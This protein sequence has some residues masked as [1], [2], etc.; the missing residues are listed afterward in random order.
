VT[1]EFAEPL[2]QTRS[3]GIRWL[4]VDPLVVVLVLLAAVAALMGGWILAVEDP[5]GGEPTAI[6]RIEPAAAVAEPAAQTAEAP[7]PPLPDLETIARNVR[8]LDPSGAPV[9][10]A[11]AAPAP[12]P[13]R[14]SV[15]S[16]APAP[17]PRLVEASEHGSLPKVGE[18]GS[19]AADVYARPVVRVA[20]GAKA[21]VAIVV[22]G[23]GL[24]ARAT[25]DAI[26]R[27]PG[28]VT[29]AFV[30]YGERVPEAA[31]KA[32]QLGHELVLQ[33][34]MEPFDYPDS[35]PGPKAL[36]ASLG[37]G[38][39]ASRLRWALGRFPGYAGVTSYMGAKFLSA[40]GALRPVLEETK[41]RGLYFLDQRTPGSLGSKV[42][43]ALKL[44]AAKSDLVLD[45]VAGAD[46]IDAK[47]AELEALAQ[48]QGAALAFA[49]AQPVSIERIARW[50]EG[51]SARG[52]LL[53]PA[54][55]VMPRPNS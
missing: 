19:R 14:E 13:A 37:P 30:P 3:S 38:E 43:G 34:P 49:S 36:L 52:I 31:G 25:N 47:L 23:L 48:T 12:D 54:S 7:A 50:A 24:G 22:T 39:N 35:D 11:T 16:L 51:L 21:R 20:G 10:G 18:D 15:L 26:L 4:R 33:L 44:Q 41:A 6:A 5:W 46:A 8:I 53:V 40:E 2:G 32:R 9:G 17:D 28:A 42:A 27:L 29:L 45:A 55:A 1:D